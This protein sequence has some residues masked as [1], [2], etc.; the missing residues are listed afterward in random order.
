MGDFC[1]R[2]KPLP[3]RDIEAV[4][5]EVRKKVEGQV[6]GLEIE[7]AQLMEDLIGDL[8][9]VPQPIEIKL[10]SDDGNLLLKLQHSQSPM[11]SKK[12]PAW[13]MSKAVSCWRVTHWTFKSIESKPAW[14][15]SIPM[16]SHKW[17]QL[18]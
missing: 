9:A 7:L 4:M 11:L 13:S 12:F 3:R 18:Y 2:L 5:N 10:Y 8:T 1:V 16:R 15:A 6:P 14:K 17:C